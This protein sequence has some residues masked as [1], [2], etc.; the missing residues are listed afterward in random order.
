MRNPAYLFVFIFVLIGCTQNRI[1]TDNV[2]AIS[3]VAFNDV[4][5]NDN[6]W[7]PRL[8]TQSRTLVPYALDKTIPAVENLINTAR[9]LKGDSSELPFL[10]RF[11]CS[12]LFKAMEGAAY[13][14]M[15]NPNPSLE[16]RLDS[17]IDIISEAQQV[18][19]YLYPSHITGVSRSQHNHFGGGGMGDKPYS[20][21]FHSHELYNMGHLYEAAIAYYMATGK[22]KLLKVAEKSAQHINKVFFVG[23]PNY[24]DGYP[25]NQAPGHQEIE[26]ALVRLYQV[27]GNDLYLEMAYKFLDIRGKTFIP[28]GEG[29]MSASYAQQHLPVAE[30]Y[31]AVGHSVRACYLYSGMADVS[32]FCGID[33]YDMALDQIWNNIVNTRMH[34]T[35]GLGAV[36]G[37]EG[38]GPEYVLPNKDAFNETCA[39]VG[40]VLFNYRMFLMSGDG[41]YMDVA[42]IALYNNVLAGTNFEGDRFFYVNPLEA[43]GHTTFNHGYAGRAP[44]FNT[45]CCPT[46]LARLIPQV[47]GMMYGYDQ[48]AIYVTL[49]AS[50]ETTI[51]LKSGD[52][53]ITQESNYPFSES[54]SILV[55]PKK[56]QR[57]ALRLRI[58]TW[59]QGKQF[60]PGS[61]YHYIHEDQQD[62]WSVKVNGE[63]HAVIFN[64]GFAEI[65]RVWSP[66]DQV[67]L[68]LTMDVKY[69]RSDIRVEANIDRISISRGP[70]V[71]CA[72]S[73][74][75]RFPAQRSIA[76]QTPDA[77]NLQT[78]KIE[79]GVLR[80]LVYIDFP[81][82]FIGEDNSE[83]DKTLELIPYY[84]WNNRGNNS[85][86]VWFPT[87]KGQL[88]K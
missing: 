50:S 21:V 18:D 20:F 27:T 24:N 55:Y 36:R 1:G 48:D 71:Y 61:L 11:I 74:D 6:F 3:Q 84:S 88:I 9:F 17:I 22:D 47:S 25:V 23:D 46:N 73:T 41:R 81:V 38:F 5:L 75:S 15:T 39:G 13:I 2:A 68:F 63:Q 67:E 78:G 62:T 12:D 87:S 77:G 28:D 16:I 29:V 43:D 8:D 53:R 52:V 4:Y 76:Y 58:P 57:F 14:L 44:W 54:T 26:L 86:L 49:Y 59:A 35:G 79:S 37:I 33:E 72:E 65:N 80:N 70:L 83:M 82:L 30:Q 51:P 69:N 60:V 66:G 31:E 40:N 32:K 85:M 42:E 7:R 19:G 45:A 10:H 34:I 64:N 56:G